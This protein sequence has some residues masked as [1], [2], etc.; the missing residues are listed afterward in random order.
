ME[1]RRNSNILTLGEIAPVK[2]ADERLVIYKRTYE[3]EQHMIIHNLSSEPI[4]FT[5]PGAGSGITFSTSGEDVI[6]G[7]NITVSAYSSVILK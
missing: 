7:D 3:N 5:M 4:S 2:N 6:N 1:L